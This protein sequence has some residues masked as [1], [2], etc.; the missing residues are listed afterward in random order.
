MPEMITC[1][2][3]EEFHPN[4][5]LDIQQA[6]DFFFESTMGKI[7][8]FG[9]AGYNLLYLDTE[10]YE[11]AD[12]VCIGKQQVV[13]RIN[14]FLSS[15]DSFEIVAWEVKD[16]IIN[17]EEQKAILN[18]HIRYLGLFD[19]EKDTIEFKGDGCFKLKSCKYGG[20]D[21]YHI[22]MSGLKI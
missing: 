19:N 7:P 5:K 17:D 2:I 21:I 16:L 10:G 8:K 12:G 11:N 3:Y 22:T 4:S 13:D 9:G 20:W 6:C 15:F 18:F 14:N 1:Y